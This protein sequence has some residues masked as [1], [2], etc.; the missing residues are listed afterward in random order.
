MKKRYLITAVLLILSILFAAMT[1]SAATINEKASALTSIGVLK[2]SIEGQLKRSEASTFVVR[3]LG[4]ESVV[5]AYTSNFPDVAP[6]AWYAPYV[7]YCTYEG[8]LTGQPD[9]KFH[10]DDYT[11]E[12]AFIKMVLVCLGY[13]YGE[14]FDWSNV[15][16]TAYMA[17]IVKDASYAS[18]TADNNKY[19]RADVVE[20]L[21]NAMTAVNIKTNVKMVQQLINDKAITLNQAIAAGFI[22]DPVQTAIVSVTATNANLLSVKFNEQIKALSDTDIVIYRKDDAQMLT[23][24]LTSQIPGEIIIST[25]NQIAD[26]DYIIEINNIYDKDGNRTGSLTGTFTGYRP[27]EL[28]SDYFRISKAVPVSK[29]IVNVYFTHPITSNSEIPSYYEI[30]KDDVVIASG[31]AK[32]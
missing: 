28:K 1:V 15:Y 22:N 20:L 29:N 27:A 21:Y 10:P 30:L 11:S 14:D 31:S 12:K 3:L 13:T 16:K 23:G 32:E 18:K 4:K 7:G 19:M 6:T 8:I 25:G 9:G 17:G 26:E 2:G 24:K 5:D